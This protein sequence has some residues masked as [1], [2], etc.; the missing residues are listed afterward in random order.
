MLDILT[1]KYQVR[2]GRYDS[3]SK[4]IQDQELSIQEQNEMLLDLEE[5]KMISQFLAK[6]AQDKTALHLYKV[7]N[8]ALSL[9]FD[10]PIEFKINIETKGDSVQA[11]PVLIENNQ[12]QSPKVSNGGGVL[13]IV[14][15]ALRVALLGMIK[16]DKTPIFILDEAFVHIGKSDLPKAVMLMKTISEQMGV[17]IITVTHIKEIKDVADTLIVTEKQNGVSVVMVENRNIDE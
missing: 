3:L 17:Q 16:K 10:E 12:E 15:F 11:T 9:V 7:V 4:Q 14:S 13:D 8:M 5:A 1:E 6:Q 2:K